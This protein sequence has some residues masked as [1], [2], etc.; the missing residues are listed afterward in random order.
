[1]DWFLHD[2]DHHH[3]RVKLNIFTVFTKMIKSLT[4]MKQALQKILMTDLDCA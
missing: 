3:E 1:M 2:W 4:A